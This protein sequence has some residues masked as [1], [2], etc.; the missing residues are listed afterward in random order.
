MPSALEKLVKI[1]KLEHEK[2]GKDTAVVGGLSDY[3]RNWEPEARRQA[4]KPAHQ[5][6]IDEIMDCLKDYQDIESEDKRK[7]RL[8]YILDRITNRAPP[9]PEYSDRLRTWTEKMAADKPRE[10]RDRRGRDHSDR[11][12]AKPQRSR[13]AGASSQKQD[14]RDDDATWDEDYTGGP[15]SREL[16]IKPLPRLERPPRI[17]RPDWS[18]EEAL[19]LYDALAAPTTDVKGIGAKFAESLKQ[20]DLHTIGQLLFHFPR[21]YLDYTEL[22]CIRDLKE[23]ETT[24][25]VATVSHAASA[26]GANQRQ[27]FL[28]RVTDGTGALSIRFFGQHYL[29]GRIQPGKQIVLNGKVSKYRDRLQMSNPEWEPADLENLQMVG[30]VPV[31]RLGKGMRPRLFRNTMKALSADWAGSLPD[32]IPQSVLDRAELADLGWAMR[33]RHFPTGR[34]H[35]RHAKRRLAFDELLMLQLA[36]LGNRRKWQSAQIAALPVS[37][38]VLT[39]FIKKAFE[40][41]LTADQHA[42]IADIRADMEKTLPMNRLIQGDVG[43]GKT[44]IAMAAMAIALGKEKQA[45]FMAPTGI[46]AEQHFRKLADAAAAF[47]GP[48]RPVVALFTSALSNSERESIYR[49]ASDGS[50]DIVVGTH[51]LI[52]EGFDFKELGIAV[53]DEQHRFGVDQRAKLRS[54]GGNPHLLVM[55]ATPIPRTLSLTVFADLDL[56]IIRE[57]PPGRRPVKTKIIDPVARERLNGFVLAQLEQGRQAFFVHPLVEESESVETASATEAFESLQKVFFRYRV[58][59]LHGR[60]SAA[61]KD[62]LMSEFSAGQHDVMVTTSVAEVGVDI[63]NASV[64]VIDGANRFGLAQLHQFRGRVGRGEHQSHCFLIPDRSS[65]INMDRVHDLLEGEAPADL[66][67][68]AER[69]LVAMAQSNDGFELAELD[70]QLRGEGDLLGWRQSGKDVLQSLQKFSPELVQLAQRE[71][72]TIYEEDPSLTLPEHQLLARRIS[73]LYTEQSELS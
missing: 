46:L 67:S 69:R 26:I 65:S 64:I 18:F 2:G 54:K 12:Q 73:Q 29:S 56:T 20:L 27:D 35:L 25:I 3:C 16:D 42:A 21:D 15:Q 1:L 34:D 63:P 70:W 59:L 49:G 7:D 6:L 28:A 10:P 43:S 68:V 30:I 8:S 44:A 71:A 17:P 11:R 13:K 39:D 31:Y 48:H 32:P 36:V 40:F 14:F 66:L 45:A 57:K 22:K 24:T 47:P 38:E 23:N 9:P 55:S 61:E 72:R 62:R 52:Q 19:A 58:C 4:R 53:I 51:S 37:D 5:I 60:M 33:Q 41:E 50:I